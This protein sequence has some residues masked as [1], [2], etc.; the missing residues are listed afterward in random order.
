MEKLRRFFI[1]FTNWFDR[2][3]DCLALIGGG[4]VGVT[5]IIVI[6]DVFMRYLIKRPSNWVDEISEFFLVY[7]TFFGAAWVLRI[8]GHT[9]IDIL[10]TLM[11]RERSKVILGVYQRI[12]SLIFCTVFTWVTWETFWDSL[13]TQ[14]RTGGGLFSV[15]LW[16]VLMVIPFGGALLCIELIIQVA[17]NSVYLSRNHPEESEIETRGA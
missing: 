15:P 16:P 11:K 2:L 9:R 12:L 3:N 4:I 6:Y 1:S 13:I 17:H 8:G 14:E 5:C 7:L 10:E